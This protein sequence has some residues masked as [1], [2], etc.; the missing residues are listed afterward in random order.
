M[1]KK[2]FLNHWIITFIM[3]FTL[4]GISY[5]QNHVSNI[6]IQQ[7]DA[8]LYVTYDLDVTSDIE[9]FVSFDNGVNFTGPLQHVSGAV[10]NGIL[11][12]KNKILVWNIFKEVGYVDNSN[13]IVKIVSNAAISTENVANAVIS[14]EQPQ[15]PKKEPSPHSKFYLGITGGNVIFVSGSDYSGPGIG[16]NGAYFFNHQLGIGFAMH[17]TQ[18]R[19]SNY[20]KSFDSYFHSSL[21]CGAMFYGHW[22]HFFNGK[23]FF[24]TNIGIG[25]FPFE[26]IYEDNNSRRRSNNNS[27][28][29]FSVGI[30]YRPKSLISIGINS[31]MYIHNNENLVYFYKDSKWGPFWLNINFHF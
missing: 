28:A 19:I 25:W 14:I 6:R 18:Q 1:S 4:L 3:M 8:M 21:F 16:F 22:G 30:A 29:L 9:V 12:E 10:G 11:P 7:H 5:A 31:N 15:K 2:L 26:E 23:L 17:Y 20:N 27:G 13:I 24:P